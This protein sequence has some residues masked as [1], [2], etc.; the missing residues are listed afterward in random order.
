MR[1][2]AGLCA[3]AQPTPGVANLDL[4]QAVERDPHAPPVGR[5]AQV[6]WRG[7]GSAL[8]D[9]A[10]AGDRELYDAAG[11]LGGHPKGM[12]V[13][14][15][16]DV[17]RTARDGGARDNTGPSDVDERDAVG[18]RT[19]DGHPS[20]VRAR[21]DVVWARRER[22]ASHQAPRR[23]PQDR[24]GV[25]LLQS[26]EGR[27][28]RCGRASLAV[29]ALGHC[30][31]SAGG[32]PSAAAPVRRRLIAGATRGRHCRDESKRGPCCGRKGGHLRGANESTLLA[33]LAVLADPLSLADGEF[34]A[35]DRQPGALHGAGPPRGLGAAASAESPGA[36]SSHHP[37]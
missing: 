2:S 28:S 30:A 26:D 31:Q 19:R 3:R 8:E 13:A 12:T 7:G 5:D 18:G 37:G 14:G 32:V 6:V 21:R 36:S 1:R 29:G 11:A 35:G 27:E 25:R 22:E 16:G 34:D 4:R 23:A 20:T 24:G 10:T 9:L 33:R 17:V 15:E